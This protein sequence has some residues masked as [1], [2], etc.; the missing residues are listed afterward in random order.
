VDVLDK[1]GCVGP[2]RPRALVEQNEH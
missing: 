2:A 1:L